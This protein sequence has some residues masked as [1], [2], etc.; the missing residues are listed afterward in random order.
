MTALS[1]FQLSIRQK[2]LKR[3]LTIGKLSAEQYEHEIAILNNLPSAP[4]AVQVSFAGKDANVV[5]QQ[6]DA[7]PDLS[8]RAISRIEELQAEMNTLDQEKA[9]LC[10]ELQAIPKTQLAA[11]EV[12]AIFALRQTRIALGDKIRAIQATGVEEVVQVQLP[13]KYDQAIPDDKYE[14][15]KL[16]RNMRSNLSKWKKNGQSVKNLERKKEYEIKYAAGSQKLEAMIQ[17]LN[18]L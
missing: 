4:P 15:D 10:N 1:N 14:L 11:N 3:Y 7:K 6:L 18:N 8:K 5:K 13:E 12:N 2:Q 17:K 9:S 16:I